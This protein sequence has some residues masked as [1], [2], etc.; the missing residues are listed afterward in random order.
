MTFGISPSGDCHVIYHVHNLERLCCKQNCL[1]ISGEP[2]LLGNPK[3]LR[4]H[5]P[6]M[7]QNAYARLE[8]RE[9][10]FFMTKRRII[11]GRNSK[12]GSVD[13]NMGA[14][15]FIS[16]KHLEIIMDGN[17]FYLLCRGKNGVFVN[18]T[19]QKREAKRLQL[20]HS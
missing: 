11:I 7:E 5:K 19:F 8:G 12:L 13:V 20:P 17:K 9:L 18:N 6:A 16:R 10:E 14:T 2:R 3:H 4:L 1:V 15:R